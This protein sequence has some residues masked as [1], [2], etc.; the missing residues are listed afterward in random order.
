MM[1]SGQHAIAA[2]LAATEAV[3]QG[4]APA[5]SVITATLAKQIASAPIYALR[6]TAM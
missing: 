4:I 6:M 1:T 2:N 3:S 5:K